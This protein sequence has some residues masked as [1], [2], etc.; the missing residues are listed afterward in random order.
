MATDHP[1][2]YLD[3]VNEFDEV[4]GR[5]LRQEIHDKKLLHRAV[6]LFLLNE[7]QELLLQKRSL[8]KPTWPGAWD[9]SVSGHLSSGQTYLDAIIRETAEE[10]GLEPCPTLTPL[11]HVPPSE[12]TDQEWITV[13]LAQVDSRTQFN[14]DPKEVE[15]T[16]WMPL[17][18][19]TEAMVARPDD[20]ARAFRTLFFLWRET[21]FLYPE[22]VGNRWYSV[23]SGGE[24]S[25]NIARGLLESAEIPTQVL[26]LPDVSGIPGR[27]LFSRRDPFAGDLAVPLEFIPSAVD[28][29]YLS[30]AGEDDQDFA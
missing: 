11:L 26:H 6:H 21:Q 12:L 25:L 27:G 30:R 23:L 9:A 18:K 17:A 20:F 8:T 29:L 1:E 15:S 22:P 2:E 16:E 24:H 7:K 19:V 28:L 10:I 4:V 13:Y 5:G 14:P 3:I